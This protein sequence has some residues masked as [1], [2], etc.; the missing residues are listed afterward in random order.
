MAQY[1]VWSVSEAKSW[2]ASLDGS[3]LFLAFIVKVP[4]NAR[5]TPNLGDDKAKLELSTINLT[6]VNA[7]L[8]L[9]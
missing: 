3:Q 7:A 4:I 2:L 9:S 8:L 5:E 1:R 6:V